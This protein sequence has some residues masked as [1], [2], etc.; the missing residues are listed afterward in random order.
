M[1]HALGQSDG[2]ERV[3][4]VKGLLRDAGRPLRHGEV[5]LALGVPEIEVARI[6]HEIALRKDGVV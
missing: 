2:I 3:D 1:T 4:A 5:S 6:G